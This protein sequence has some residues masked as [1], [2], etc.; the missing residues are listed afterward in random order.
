MDSNNNDRN[1]QSRNWQISYARYFT[2]DQKMLTAYVPINCWNGSEQ[3]IIS[4]MKKLPRVVEVSE[5]RCLS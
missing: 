5:V 3:E 4:K 2:F 1:V